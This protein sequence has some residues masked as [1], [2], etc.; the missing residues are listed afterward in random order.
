MSV[1]I[2]K[3]LKTTLS[4]PLTTTATSVVLKKLQDSKGNNLSMSHF[5]EWGVIVI[6]QGSNIEMIKFNA[7]STASDNK[8][9]LTV[10]TNGR[11]LN[12]TQPYAGSS[13]GLSFQSGAEVI[14]SNDP[15]TLSN[16]MLENANTWQ[17]IQ[18]FSKLPS[19]TAGNPVADND[20]ARKAY[21]DSQ[22]TGGATVNRIIV[23]GTA[24]ATIAAGNLI[25]LDTADGEWKLCDADIA[26][27]VD[28]VLL[29]IAQGAGTDGNAITNGVLLFGLDSNQSGMT[30][31]QVQYA[32]NTA[33][34]ISNVAGTTEVT[35]GIANSATT[36]YFNPRLNQ[37]ITEN[38]QDALAGTSGIPSASNKYVTE[39][40]VSNAAAADKIVRATGTA[41]PALSGANL[42]N[43]PTQGVKYGGDGSDGALTVTSGTT[44]IDLGGAAIFIKNYS[45]ISITGTG[46]VTFSNPHAGGTIV[47]F[48]CQ[49]NLVLTSTTAPMIDLTG[50]GAA[51]GAAE[52]NGTEGNGIVDVSTS[53]KGV[54]A[55]TTSGAS[56]GTAYTEKGQYASDDAFRL[57]RL[58]RILACGSGGGGG[59]S[60]A[61]ATGGAGGRGGGVLIIECDGDIN[62]TTANGISVNGTDGTAGGN[63]IGGGA[64]AGGG[65]GG[66]AGMALI[67][68]KTATA[69]SGTITAAGGKGG[70][71]GLDDGLGSGGGGGGSG[72]GGYGGSGGNGANQ[73]TGN[74]GGGGG[75]AGHGGGG[76]TAS[77]TTGG[78]AGATG[79]QLVV[80]N[81]YFG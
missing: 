76:G 26:S 81:N 2:V 27:S 75:G 22:A 16:F 52:S 58:T 71:G 24:G 20:L 59:D 21:V 42:T 13:T 46:K 30:A 44:N 48:K 39:N 41:L 73:A 23:A 17:E 28:N 55:T 31:G 35:V 10:A 64:G 33:G 40:D 69:T 7:I 34:A 12:P 11:H 32:S 9:T 61:G 63:G 14:V 77:G 29:G 38:E 25:Y 3:A 1:Y 45:S 78:V 15:Y 49:G 72:A 37:Q 74:G 65:G 70:N 18:T 50:I 56:G 62:F 8:A 19:T 53:H 51:G 60:V 54:G 43:L 4:S 66:A 6:K 79:T 36:L 68:Y 67:T 80:A 5:G 57:S 47:I